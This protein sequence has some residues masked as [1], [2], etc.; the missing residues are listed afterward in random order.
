MKRVGY[1][2]GAPPEKAVALSKALKNR[3]P[4]RS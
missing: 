4:Y 1:F 2:V 3:W